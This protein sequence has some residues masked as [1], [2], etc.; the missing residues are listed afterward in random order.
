[1]GNEINQVIDNLCEKLGTTAAQLA[2]EFA[3]MEIARGVISIAVGI[4]ILVVAIY[5]LRRN[6]KLY[7]KAQE[8]RDNDFPYVFGAIVFGIAV[9]ISIIA[10]IIDLNSLIGWIASPQAAFIEHMST[11]IKG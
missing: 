9:F 1:M 3:R 11:M 8:D 7:F 10:L 4:L 6:I 5:F 2:P